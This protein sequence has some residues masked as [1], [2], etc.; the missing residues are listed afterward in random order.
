M[1]WVLIFLSPKFICLSREPGTTEM[2][3]GARPK[4]R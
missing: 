3:T 2:E 1:V 4:Q